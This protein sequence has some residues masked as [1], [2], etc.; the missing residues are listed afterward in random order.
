M[1]TSIF[2]EPRKI[3]ESQM[4]PNIDYLDKLLHSH[5]MWYCATIMT[6]WGMFMLVY[7]QKTE[8]KNSYKIC[9]Q[10]CKIFIET[11]WREIQQNTKNNCFLP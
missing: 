5:L 4:A 11:D 8:Q 9:Y 2:T 6:T 10:V 3:R 7:K 1:L